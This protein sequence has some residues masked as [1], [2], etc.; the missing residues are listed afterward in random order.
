MTND[1]EWAGVK[2]GECRLEN[3]EGEEKYE[4]RMPIDEVR[5]GY[6][7]PAAGGRSGFRGMNE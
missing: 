5:S 7:T 4:C 3:G 1:E 2:S 6:H